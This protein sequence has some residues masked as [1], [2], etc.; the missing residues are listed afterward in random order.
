MVSVLGLNNI[1]RKASVFA[2]KGYWRCFFQ[3]LSNLLSDNCCEGQVH[4]S[5]HDSS[6]IKEVAD[7]VELF[8]HLVHKAIVKGCLLPLVNLGEK[9]LQ[10]ILDSCIKRVAIFNQNIA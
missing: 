4:N 8:G 3:I 7:I 2:L 1:L 6:F 5:A 10:Q 9:V